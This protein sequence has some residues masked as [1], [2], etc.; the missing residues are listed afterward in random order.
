MAAVTPSVTFSYA[1]GSKT[2][3]RD[4]RF[5]LDADSRLA[6]VGPNVRAQAACA[7]CAASKGACVLP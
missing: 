7:L 1:P 3:F 4:M 6:I 2:I 5:G